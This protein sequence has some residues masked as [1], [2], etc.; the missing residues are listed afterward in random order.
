MAANT[1]SGS[2]PQ[3]AF[4]SPDELWEPAVAAAASAGDSVSAILNRAL[5]DY[6][7]VEVPAAWA[8]P[9]SAAT[10]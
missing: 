2:T 6:L 9:S 7:G 8:A 3:R 4:R 1:G 5:A 10:R